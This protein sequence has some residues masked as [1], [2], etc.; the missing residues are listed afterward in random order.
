MINNNWKY[1]LTIITL[2]IFITEL[3]TDI[4]VP[5]LPRIASAFNTSEYKVMLTVSINLIGLS[6][7]GLLYGPLSDAIG[8]KKVLLLGITIFCFSSLFCIYVSTIELIVFWR[9]LQGIGGGASV[10]VGLATISDIYK[11]NERAKMMSRLNMV[12]AFSPVLG[13]IIGSQI[14]AY[15]NRW[16]LPLAIIP[17]LAFP[18]LLLLI[19]L[20]KETL[21]QTNIGINFNNIKAS[22][23][24]VLSNKNFICYLLIQS[25]TFG[26]LW[27]DIVNLP[28]IFIKDMNVPT[29]H[30]GYYIIANVTVYIIGIVA[31][32]KLVQFKGPEK[33]I[34]YGIVLILFSGISLT[35]ATIYFTLT[36]YIVLLLKLPAAIGVGFTLGNASALSLMQITNYGTASAII[37]STEMLL[38]SLGI[39]IISYLY[40]GT[41]LP[42]S[43]LVVV[44]SLI[45]LLIFQKIKSPTV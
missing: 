20:F 44:F 3:A 7:S 37:G 6:L 43:I 22:F 9:L 1:N 2:L 5:S 23:K 16:Y 10:T 34:L 38:G 12:V 25:L 17:S 32:Q 24:E 30:Y 18:V 26:W 15:D 33:M 36:A 29:E 14:A 28:F 31:N 41:I 27:A 19:T 8:R 45:S 11:G 40:N 21:T 13:P 4:Y 42:L 35:F 39:K